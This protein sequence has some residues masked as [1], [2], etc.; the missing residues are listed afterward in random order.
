MYKEKVIFIIGPTGVGKTKLSVE[1]AKNINGEIINCDVLQMYNGLDVITNKATKIERQN[2]LH[3]MMGFLEY[4]EVYNVHKYVEESLKIVKEII[5]K[6]KIPI[7]VGGTNL[8]IEGLLYELYSFKNENN[9][10]NENIHFNDKYRINKSK[11]IDIEKMEN[12]KLKLRF[13]N[14]FIIYLNC[15][16]ANEYENRITKRSKNILYENGLKELFDFYSKNDL[17]NEKF[18]MGIAKAIGVKEFK[19]LFEKYPNFLILKDFLNLL[20]LECEQKFI[21]NTIKYSKKQN[22]LIKN[23]FLNDS[24][25]NIVKL[26]TLDLIHWEQNVLQ[27]SIVFVNK[28]VDF[29]IDLIDYKPKTKLWNC[30]VDKE[31]VKTCFICNNIQ[32][33]GFS[34]WNN[35]L[36][37]RKHKRYLKKFKITNSINANDLKQH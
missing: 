18:K 30:F 11:T 14:H 22:R 17:K 16:D 37:S 20:Y 8:Y 34:Q 35:H 12:Y 9:I 36:K 27:P 28:F 4:H 7:F 26:D 5:N 24:N 32:I 1:I 10:L 19:I 21:K 25:L 15:S 23:R 31:K 6:N 13:I 2:I 3:H 29:N 33:F